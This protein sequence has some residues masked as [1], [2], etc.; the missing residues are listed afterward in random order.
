MI[1]PSKLKFNKVD[2]W[3][4]TNFFPAILKY[5]KGSI[6][7]GDLPKS[8]I[9]VDKDSLNE[10]SAELIELVQ[11]K[12]CIPNIFSMMCKN[13]DSEEL[14]KE[15]LKHYPEKKIEDFAFYLYQFK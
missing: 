2:N 3:K 8:V 4:S 6:L 7:V 9:L 11:F 5:Q 13:M 14:E 12:K 1:A 10:Y 15:L